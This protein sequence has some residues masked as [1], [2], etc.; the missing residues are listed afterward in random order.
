MSRHDKGGIGEGGSLGGGGEGGGGG[1]MLMW[2]PS[3]V[4][5]QVLGMG[6][7][8]WIEPSAPKVIVTPYPQTC[9][10]I[11]QDTLMIM[12]SLWSL[13]LQFQQRLFEHGCPTS[14]P[15]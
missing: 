14:T 4:S 8:N 12:P 6:L 7:V 10:A 1:E 3:H 11:S 13:V 9:H 5:W 2:N 15:I